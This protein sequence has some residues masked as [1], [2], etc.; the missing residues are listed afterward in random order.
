MFKKISGLC[1]GKSTTN[2]DR[3]LKK[4]CWLWSLI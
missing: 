4:I 1:A 2:D 3:T